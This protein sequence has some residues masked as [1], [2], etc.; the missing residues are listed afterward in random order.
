MVALAVRVRT[1]SGFSS[2]SLTEA[3]RVASHLESFAV[4]QFALEPDELAVAMHE[5]QQFARLQPIDLAPQLRQIAQRREIGE[6]QFEAAEQ[7]IHRVVAA[8]DHL[9]GRETEA[10]LMRSRRWPA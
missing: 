6:I 3:I 1:S 9:D 5:A 7:A 10:R 8:D 2:T 4:G